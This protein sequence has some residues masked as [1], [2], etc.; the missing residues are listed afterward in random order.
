MPWPL[1]PQGKSP[2]HPLDRGLGGP[3][4]HS[5]HSGENNSQP[6]LVIET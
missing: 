5:G 4:S 6:P 2:W 3:P 1:Y